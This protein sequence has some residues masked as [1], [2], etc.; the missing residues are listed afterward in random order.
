MADSG[1]APAQ[2]D[3]VREFWDAEPCGTRY[4][5][6]DEGFDAH[7]HT[8]YGLEPYIPEFAQFAS[9]RGLKVLE[10]GVGMG[11]DYLEWLKAGALATG[12]DLSSASL[13]RARRRCADA[14][15]PSDLQ[16]AD[17]EKLPFPDNTFDV[18]YS[19]GVM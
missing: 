6:G 7:A 11:A 13:D 9:A 19:Y 3:E 8:R 16:V 18:V 14:G 5:A 4:L 10:V 15:Y 1:T 2:K 17:A 12:V